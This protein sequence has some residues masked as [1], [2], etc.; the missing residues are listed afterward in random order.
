MKS[1]V[2][3]RVLD[4][5]VGRQPNVKRN[6]YNDNA[7][8]LEDLMEFCSPFKKTVVTDLFDVTVTP[9]KEALVIRITGKNAY[10]KAA[11][12]EWAEEAIAADFQDPDE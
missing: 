12:V 11:C 8:L 4:R 6:Q 7:T 1:N 3:W 5:V 9:D 10:G 2:M